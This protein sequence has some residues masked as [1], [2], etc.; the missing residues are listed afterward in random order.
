MGKKLDTKK[1]QYRWVNPPT[2]IFSVMIE[3]PCCGW[4]EIPHAAWPL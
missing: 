4:N 3:K 2:H 1:K